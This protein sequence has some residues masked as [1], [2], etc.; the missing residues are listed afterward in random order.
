[1]RNVFIGATLGLAVG[2]AAVMLAGISI[3]LTVSAGV[4][5]GTT[6][7]QIFAIDRKSVV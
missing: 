7:A 3:T 1:M 5:A 2:G 4:V 6:G